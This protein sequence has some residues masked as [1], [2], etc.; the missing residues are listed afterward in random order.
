MYGKCRWIMSILSIV[1]IVLAI[2]PSIIGS[3]ASTWVIVAAAALI[4]LHGFRCKACA[5]CESCG[6]SLTGKVP[7]R[8]SKRRR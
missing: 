6:T 4:L 1:I 3:V 5:N 8:K 7:A 2:W